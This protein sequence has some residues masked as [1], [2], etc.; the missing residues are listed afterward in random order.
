[1]SIRVKI[2]HNTHYSY[3]T[4]VF[5][6]PHLIRLRPAPHCRTEIESYSLTI[7]SAQHSIHWQQDAFNNYIARL[8]FPEKLNELSLRVE[9][10]ANVVSFNAYN[11]FIDDYAMIW[12]FSYKDDLALDLTS[13]LKPQTHDAA[14]HNFISEFEYTSLSTL[15]F[16]IAINS[17][18]YKKV[19]YIERLESGV[20]SC[21][22]TLTLGSG[23]CRDSAWLLVQALRC[24]GLAARF[25]SGYSLQ[26]AQETSQQENEIKK[27]S[28]DLHAWTEVYIPGAGWIGLDPS[29][30]LLAGEG[31]IPL[32][33]T[34]EP[35]SAAPVSG[36]SGACETTLHF[37][38]TI[39]RL[40]DRN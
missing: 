21:D 20:Q 35:T 1:M 12:P 19:S 15:D 29:S 7:S 18:I 40:P 26:L 36:L 10:T 37:E 22:T 34:R 38:N 28:T 8:I 16:L 23:S 17:N 33:C 24:V 4:P 32:C 13:Y 27:D 39:I 25:V 31:Y 3:S 11:F 2:N 5:L 9:I 14:M 6:T 30:G